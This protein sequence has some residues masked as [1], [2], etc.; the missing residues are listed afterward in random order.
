ME[1]SFSRKI[2]KDERLERPKRK[3]EVGI[4][5]GCKLNMV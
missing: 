5:Y 4:K 3:W 1:I 2:P